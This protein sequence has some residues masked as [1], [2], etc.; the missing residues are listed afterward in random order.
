MLRKASLIITI[1]LVFILTCITGCGTNTE[2]TSPNS[3]TPVSE[4]QDTLLVYSGAGLRNAT[5]EIAQVFEEKYN[6][7]I[8]YHYT[9]SAQNLAQIELTQEGDLYIPGALSYGKKAEEKGFVSNMQNVCYHIPVIAVPEGNPAGIEKLEDLS[10]SGVKVVLGDPKGPA[11]GKT[12]AK[13]LKNANILDAVNTNLESTT[14]TVNEIV[15][16]VSMKQCDA[17]IIW[18]DN[19]VGV[20]GIEVI[21]ITPEQND[22]KTV[23]VC[24]LSFSQK[25]E[26]AQNFADFIVSQEGKNIFKKHGF[27][28]VEN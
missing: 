28:P 2:T 5:D 12:A 22:I 10:K 8:E 16:Y 21:Q 17:A 13:I 26:L 14:A 11:I 15:T 23:P 18:E 19:A 25:E 27:K 3:N 9:G 7:K 20:D 6:V 24:V 4:E 1:L